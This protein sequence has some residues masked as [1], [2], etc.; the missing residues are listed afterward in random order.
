VGLL[1]LGFRMIPILGMTNV[2]AESL[3]THCLQVR[4]LSLL[5]FRMIPS[6]ES[7]ALTLQRVY[8]YAVS[9]S[10]AIRVYFRA[11][12]RVADSHAA[13]LPLLAGH[14]RKMHCYL[15]LGLDQRLVPHSR[16][17]QRELKRDFERTPA[18]LDEFARRRELEHLDLYSR[19]VY[20][21]ALAFQGKVTDLIATNNA[22]ETLLASLESC[23]L[24]Q[25]EL[26]RIMA[27]L[28]QIVSQLEL[29]T[30]SNL[31]WF[32][33]Q[34]DARTEV[35][36]L[37]RL[38]EMVQLWLRCFQA[39]AADAPDAALDPRADSPAGGRVPSTA[40]HPPTE[41]MRGLLEAARSRLEIKI[42]NAVLVVE[43]PIEVARAT[44]LRQLSAQMGIIAEIPRIRHT[45]Y[46]DF[47][48]ESREATNCTYQGLV[49]QLP[50]PLLQAVYGM[51]EGSVRE[52]DKYVGSWL[53]YQSLW[54]LEAATVVARLGGDVAEWLAVVTDLRACR[55]MFDT[56]ETAK[57][58]GAISVDFSK[59]QAAVVNKFEAWHK[60]MVAAF[61]G[62]LQEKLTKLLA[63][64]RSARE[65]LEQFSADKGTAD[66][67]EFLNQMQAFKASKEQ[68]GELMSMLREGER[69]LQKHRFKFPKDWTYVDMIEG[70][71]MAFTQI[72]A[73]KDLELADKVATLQTKIIDWDKSVAERIKVAISDWNSSKPVQGELAPADALDQL[74]LF[75]TNISRLQSDQVPGECVSSVLLVCC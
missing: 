40:R 15:W 5:G 51:I 20:D 2:L 72:Y 22:I 39:D 24:E 33:A 8:P 26:H 71:W 13:L 64:L 31:S 30:L 14:K 60:A 37:R 62:V 45:A 75:H 12:A 44:W 29:A 47:G 35:I 7:F 46:S 66:A 48:L 25:P 55:A 67:V 68:W 69:T 59:V 16:E 63:D 65:Q 21:C 43:P 74:A 57:S 56:E 53:A 6:I 36:L 3:L 34:L 38:E 54:D 61:A 1:L 27:A 42:K 70:E 9:L 50:A 32:A 23:P 11:A 18:F 28:Q 10:E 4:S 49:Y 73:K 19:K 17:V 41:H 58:F 52:C